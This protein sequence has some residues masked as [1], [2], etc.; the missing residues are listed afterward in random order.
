M[1]GDR[2]RYA[3]YFAPEPRSKLARF[4]AAWLGYD[5]AAGK[6]VAQPHV[7]AIT[8]ERLCA[9][10]AEPRRYGFH[11]T[12]KPPFALAKSADAGALDA[13]VAALASGLSAFAAPN[14]QLACLSGFWALMPSEPSPM[15]DQLAAICVSEFDRFR[16][17]PL[18]EEVAR[19]RAAELS[20][21]QEVLLERWGY[22]YVMEEFRFHMTLT[23]RLDADESTTVGGVLERLVE[24]FRYPLPVDAIGLFRQDRRDTPFRL[25]R[26]YA[27]AG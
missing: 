23:A 8:P 2:G 20:P 10:T 22:P 12:L 14:L 11:A 21:A 4:G 1:A 5:V 18:A 9:I 19:R 7:A 13:A 16:A 27:L 24:P 25:V 15:I 6:A 17:P 3:I 26:R